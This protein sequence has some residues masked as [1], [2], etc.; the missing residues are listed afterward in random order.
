MDSMSSNYW[1]NEGLNSTQDE[2]RTMFTSFYDATVENKQSQQEASA[3][4]V[5]AIS[6]CQNAA[7]KE[8]TAELR[9]ACIVS[10]SHY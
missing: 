9:T 2:P 8:A 4:G 5:P 1:Q 10:D 3:N 7:M 6:E